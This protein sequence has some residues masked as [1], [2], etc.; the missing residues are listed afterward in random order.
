MK[1]TPA[2]RSEPAGLTPDTLVTVCSA[3]LRACCWQGEFMCDSARTAG[4]TQRTVAELRA[5]N[6]GEHE[7]YWNVDP[8][9]GVRAHQTFVHVAPRADACEHD[10]QGWRP[11]ADGNGGEQVCTKCGIGAM[12]YSLAVGP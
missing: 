8:R 10:F 6:Y 12:A 11:F 3:C 7:S 2:H 4:T 5:G 1:I 9:T